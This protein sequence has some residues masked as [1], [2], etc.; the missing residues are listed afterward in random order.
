MDCDNS[1]DDATVCRPECNWAF[2]R[3]GLSFMHKT[4]W[5]DLRFVLAVAESGSVSA[6]ARALG[7]N[8]A[9]VLRRIAAFEDAEGA[10]LFDRT[11]QGYVVPPDRL[12]VIEAAR[13]AAMAIEAVSRM[14][15]GAGSALS[16]AIR[17]TSTDTFCTTVLPGIVAELQ[18]GSP[19]LRIDLICTN[20]HVDM[21]RLNAD[22]TVRPAQRL[23]DDLAGEAAGHL[24]L[25]VYA[26]PGQERA[27]WLGLRGAISRS[28][29]A[30]WIEQTVPPDQVTGGADSFVVLREMV[31]SGLGRAFLPVCLAEG[32]PR[33]RRLPDVT[34]AMSVP[35]WVASHVDLAEAPRL[36][37]LR[38]RLVLALKA[39][40]SRLAG[41]PVSL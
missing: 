7:V 27:L 29:V 5:D 41:A 16:G 31:A 26:P 19:G 18:A 8:H 34:P 1:C 38:S 10:A 23:P 36:R 13:E 9:T 35:I 15:R 21:A 22:I 17:I 14:I 39:Q 6:A 11:P 4:N 3:V 25:G 30:A 20:A 2:L 12:R 24:G 28:P 33:L 32:D 40:R 37:Q